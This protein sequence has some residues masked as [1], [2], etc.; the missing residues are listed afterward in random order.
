MSNDTDQEVVTTELDASD[1][2]R[3]I[4][5]YKTGD[6]DFILTLPAGCRM[7]F[8]YFNP[9]APRENRNRG[10]GDQNAAR[11]T[12]LRV[13][14]D[15]TDK[16]QIAAFLGVSGFRDESIKLTKLVRKIT[17]EQRY[18]DDGEGTVEYGG[19]RLAE[20]SASEEDVQF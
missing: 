4:R 10:Y 17:V 8:G 16:S 3:T 6:D 19:K 7:T 18:V 13:Y 9:A 11:Q 12:C 15:N 2:E 14:S 1:T 5:V 20:L